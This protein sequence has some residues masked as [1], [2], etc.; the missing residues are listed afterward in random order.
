MKNT[1]F[2]TGA[3][4]GIGKVTAIYF[5]QKGWNVAATLRN[6][7]QEIDLGNFENIKC[8][9]LDV[10]D[11]NSIRL[12]FHQALAHFGQIDVLVNNAGYAA[13]GPF[14]AADKAQ[15]QR[16]FDTNVLGLMSVCQQFIPYFRERKSGTIINIASVGGQITFPL[17]SL[18]HGTKWAVE[19]F[20]ESLSYELKPFNIQVKIIEPGAIKTDFYD[21]SPDVL[22]REGLIAYD[23]YVDRISANYLKAAASAPGPQVVA[24][25]IY[26]AA[27]SNNYRLRY[28]VGSGA[29]FILFLRRILP[30][31]WFMGMIHKVL[32]R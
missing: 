27:I 22:E 25:T 23:T 30:N 7:K 20:S 17:Y 21:R 26:Q 14:E 29:P 9:S 1:I 5:A 16:Q 6:P 18:Y 10:L 12:A 32:N 24:K 13:I 15:I 28:A 11:E 3:S 31:A 8:Y 19:G 2:I 4:S